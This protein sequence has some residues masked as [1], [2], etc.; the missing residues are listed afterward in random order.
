M[1]NPVA[2]A[3]NAYINRF[4]SGWRNRFLRSQSNTSS[5]LYR[6]PRYMLGKRFLKYTIDGSLM[7]PHFL[8]YLES[9][10][11]TN[12]ISKL[13]VS[14]SMFSNLIRA[15]VLSGSSRSTEISKKKKI[16]VLITIL[17][18]YYTHRRKQPKSHFRPII[19]PT[20][21]CWPLRFHF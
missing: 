19:Y 1:T 14:L 6:L 18:L 10:I 3:I 9:A 12:V 21:S 13:S 11:L 2:I 20:F 4:N 15:C 17:R 8:A 7:T 16:F 5:S